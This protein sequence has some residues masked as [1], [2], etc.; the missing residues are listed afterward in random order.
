MAK[1]SASDRIARVKEGRCPIHG[2]DMPQIAW[3]SGGS[4]QL[5]RVACP[6]RDC[7]IEGVSAAPS[8]PVELLPE[9]TALLGPNS[10]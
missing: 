1:Q 8:G 10:R 6:R 9:F 7:S 4:E 3:V 2:I 5:F